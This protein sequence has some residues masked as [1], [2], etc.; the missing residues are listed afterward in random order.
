M[1][2]CLCLDALCARLPEEDALQVALQAGLRHVEF[3]DWRGRNVDALAERLRT[4]RC[5]A[6]IFSGNT[7]DEPLVDADDHPRALAHLA[8]SMEVARRLGAGLLVAHVGYSMVG[9]PRDGQ[10][11]AAVQGLR[12]AGAMAEEAGV[13]LAVEPLNSV[14]DHPGYFLDTLPAALRLLDEVGRPSVRL[15]LDVYHMRMMHEDLLERLPGALP[16]TVHIHL[17]DVPGRGEP[18]TG[19][20]DWPAVLRILE[21]SGYRGALGLECWPSADPVSAVRRAAAVLGVRR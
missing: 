13:V 9:R 2:L 4:L 17:A 20:I 12:T 19:T 10:W 15:L 21:R 6:V 18:G 7:F 5:R 14:L 1:N 16:Y 11:A 3:W 8:R